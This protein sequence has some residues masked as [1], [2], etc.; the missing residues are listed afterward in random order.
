MLQHGDVKVL[1]QIEKVVAGPSGNGVPG[2]E[3]HFSVRGKG[4]YSVQISKMDYTAQ[5]AMAAIKAYAE[6]IAELMDHPG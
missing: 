2:L 3:I 6:Q 4:D 5:N 1:H